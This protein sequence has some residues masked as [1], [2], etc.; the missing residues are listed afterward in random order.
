MNKRPFFSVIIPCYNSKKTIGRLLQ[1]IVDQQCDRDDI[2]VVISDDCSTE[3]YQKQIEPFLNKL[4]IKQ[5]KTD[6][7]KCPG[8]TRQKGVD[9][10]TGQWIIFSDHD[11]YFQPKVFPKVKESI[12][13]AKNKDNLVG[14]FTTFN[15]INPDGSIRDIV[16][17]NQVTGWTHGK[18]FNLDKFWKGFNIH[19]IK[20]LTSHEDVS[21]NTQISCILHHHPELFIGLSN[22][23]TY[24]W[25]HR[26][27]SLSNKTYQKEGQ[28]FVRPF[29]DLFFVD[30]L[31]S[32]SDIVLERYQQFADKNSL[33]DTSFYKNL[34][35]D[36]LLLAYFYTE[37]AIYWNSKYLIQNYQ[38]SNQLFEAIKKLFKVTK[39]DIYKMFF[40]QRRQAYAEVMKKSII[41][42]GYILYGHTFKEWLKM[43][44]DKQ[45]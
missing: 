24:N 5:V 9:N 36:T 13:N 28:D 15:S 10:A 32:T 37:F 25:V 45:Y 16:R 30:Y 20:D 31:K 38:K 8:N 41:G 27:E 44:E 17:P 2:Q 3:S 40:I 23:V 42:T 33:K 43:I 7:N 11:D 12:L 22:L 35:C 1:S 26:R 29:L 21:I 14:I 6:Y 39:E 4:I 34:L 18:F 19:Y